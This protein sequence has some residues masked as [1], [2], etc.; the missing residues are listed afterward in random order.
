L[1]DAL[2]GGL[3]LL[4]SRSQRQSREL[5]RKV[6]AFE[7][8]LWPHVKFKVDRDEFIELSTGGRVMS[9]PSSPDTIA[10]FSCSVT[11]DEFARHKNSRAVWEALYGSISTQPWFRVG[12]I[13][14]PLGCQGMFYDLVQDAEQ[15][16]RSIW[17]LHK[18][19]IFQAVKNG[20]PHNIEELRAGCY[21]E[22]VWRQSYL[23]EFID[24]A[25]ALLP[26]DMLNACVDFELEYEI[27]F[28]KARK[29]NHLYVGVDIGRLK[30][31][32]VIVVLQKTGKACAGL[33]AWC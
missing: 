24:D 28:E 26:Y 22:Q 32:F 13:S 8:L 15:N 4:S 31:L 3:H 14:T 9:V 2:H 33:D 7:P 10:S 5:L 23:C 1:G 16:P 6:R 30:D 21:D 29:L 25:Y 20:C 27:D 18:T 11:L 19:D 12:I 17:S